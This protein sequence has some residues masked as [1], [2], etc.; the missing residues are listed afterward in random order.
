MAASYACWVRSAPATA[1]TNSRCEA[2]NVPAGD[3]PANRTHGPVGR[4]RAAPAASTVPSGSAADSSARAAV[5]PIAMTRLPAR[6]PALTRAAEWAPTSNHSSCGPH[7]PLGGPCMQRGAMMIPA[8]QAADQ[9]RA[10]RTAGARHLGA[11]PTDG[12]DRLVAL[13][14]IVVRHV[15]VADRTGVVSQVVADPARHPDA[16]PP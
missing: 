10:E 14:R 7:A 15:A 3:Q 5:V 12:E 16:G 4:S 11:A 13:D 2:S 1:S 9:F 6:A 8:G